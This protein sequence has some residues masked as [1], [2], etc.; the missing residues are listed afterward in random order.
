M[1]FNMKKLILLLPFIPLVFYSQIKN[2]ILES[3]L[4]IFVINTENGVSIVDEPKITAHLGI[5]YNE[6]GKRNYSNDIF[7]VYDGKVGIEIRGNSTRFFAEKKSYNFETRDD[8][9]ENLN[10]SILGLPSE[11]DWVLRASYFDHTFIRNPLAGYMSRHTGY[12]A[13]KTKHVEVMLN[14]EYQGIYILI[15]DIKRDKNRIDIN[16]LK[17]NE[18]SGEDLT[19]GYI[20]EVTGNGN[21]FGEKRKLIYPKFKNV[22]PTQLDYITN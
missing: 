11:N 20:W 22:H 8:S 17:K 9:G 15:E 4:P 2:E 10:V 14:G 1:I 19:G 6:D 5:I 18:I 3:N 7:N 16:K 21:N 13:P 12:W